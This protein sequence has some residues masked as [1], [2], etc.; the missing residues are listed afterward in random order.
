MLATPAGVVKGAPRTGRTGRPHSERTSEG[1][2]RFPVLP[3]D[4]RMS[5]LYACPMKTQREPR[6]LSSLKHGRE[7]TYVYYGCGCDLCRL[8]ATEARRIRRRNE[9]RPAPSGEAPE[10]YE[11][12]ASD[13]DSFLEWKVPAVSSLGCRF[14]EK[15]ITCGKP[16]AATLFRGSKTGTRPYNYCADHLYGRWIENGKVMHWRLRQAQP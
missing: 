10:G 13:E 12:V 16:A 7:S 5:T 6:S 1:R 9:K 15:R 2:Y 4:G 14:T 8:A 3:L 11:W